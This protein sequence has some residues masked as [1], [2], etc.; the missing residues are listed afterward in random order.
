MR[1]LKIAGIVAAIAWMAFTSYRLEYAIEVAEQ[2]CRMS[3]A[4]GL[5][6]KIQVGVVPASCSVTISE[7]PREIKPTP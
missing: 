6:A 3:Y 4:I 2:T 7:F 5:S 1:A